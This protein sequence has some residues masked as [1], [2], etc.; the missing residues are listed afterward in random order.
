MPVSR[1]PIEMFLGFTFLV[2][3]EYG[4]G[5]VQEYMEHIRTNAETS[6]RNLLRTIAKKLGTELSAIDYLDDG[7]PVR[8]LRYQIRELYTHLPFRYP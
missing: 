2:V 5:K 1:G 7:T 3:E 8:E 4:L 6:V